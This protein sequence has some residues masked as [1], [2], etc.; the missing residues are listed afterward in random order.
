M[1][2]TPQISKDLPMRILMTHIALIALVTVAM[3]VS[4][5]T[6]NLIG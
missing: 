3:L 4:L 2:P 1:N 6:N 5:P